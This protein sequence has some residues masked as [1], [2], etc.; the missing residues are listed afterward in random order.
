MKSRIIKKE[1]VNPDTLE[2]FKVVFRYKIY[3]EKEI[4]IELEF[5]KNEIKSNS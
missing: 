3:I 4:I 1:Y 5:I 2:V